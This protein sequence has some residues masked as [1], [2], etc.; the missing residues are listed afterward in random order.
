MFSDKDNV[1]TIFTLSFYFILFLSLYSL[2][3]IGLVE[4]LN[5]SFHGIDLCL[6]DNAIWNA[7]RGSW[8]HCNLKHS[9]SYLGTHFSPILFFFVPFYWLGAGSWVLILVRSA[10]MGGGAFLLRRYAVKYVKLPE[11][12]ADILGISFLLHPMV[13]MASLSEFHGM[14]L[15]LFFVPLFFVAIGSGKKWFIWLSLF[16]LLSIREDTWIYATGISLFI[17]WRENKKLAVQIAIVAVAWEIIALFL[18]MP[19]FQRGLGA[20]TQGNA[21]LANYLTR[22]KG[23]TFSNLRVFLEPRLLTDFKMLLPLAFLP[24]F[25]GRYLILM[26]IPLVQIQTGQ[27]RYQMLLLS[28]YSSCVI[29]FAYVSGVHGWKKI[30]EFFRRKFHFHAIKIDSFIIGTLILVFSIYGLRDSVVIKKK[31]PFIFQKNLIHLRE[32]TAYEIL[33]TIPLNTT[34]SLQGSLLL[35]GEHRSHV[36]LFSGYPP[37]TAYPS[38]KTE[39]VMVDLARDFSLVGNFKRE[40]LDL[41][42]SGEYGVSL[43]RDGF[44]LLKRGYSVKLNKKVK[45]EIL[46]KVQ[47]EAMHYLTGHWE[48]ANRFDWKA[49][50]V[51][52]EGRDRK[53][54]MGFGIHRTLQPGTYKVSYAMFLDGSVDT[55]AATLVLK[56][57]RKT[58]GKSILIKKIVRFSKKKFKNVLYSYKI[59]VAHKTTVEPMVFF[60]GYGS[61]GLDYVMFNRV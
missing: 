23:Y 16:L 28:H 22:Y 2:T 42:S 31:G 32:R 35:I 59:T 36:Y 52:R 19:F 48:E 17:L 5:M 40:I 43:Y 27:I 50:R 1:S 21:Q 33:K 18:F 37:K 38:Q 41:L 11:W 39:Y 53:G 58:K 8:L 55:E 15:E 9:W 4:L 10:A 34:L 47:G 57:W 26:L 14:V 51:A 44:V 6:Y 46:F 13:H 3:R 60:D 29:P 56:G 20:M 45:N 49:S 30:A 7:S 12:G 24:F 25:G 61:V 54:V